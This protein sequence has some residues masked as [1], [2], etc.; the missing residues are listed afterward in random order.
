MKKVVKSCIKHLFDLYSVVMKQIER[1]IKWMDLSFTDIGWIIL[2]NLI[3]SFALV[4]I[5]IPSKITEGG[6]LGLSIVWSK[7]MGT[8]PGLINLPIDIILYVLGFIVLKGGFFKKAIFSTLMY[9]L[10]YAIVENVGPILPSFEQV[11]LVAAVVGGILI[12]I[13]C[14]LVVS[15]GCVAG[16]D[17]CYALIASSKTKLSLSQA[18]FLAD[19]VVLTLSLFVY[20]P[21][22]NVLTSLVTT[23]ISSFIIGQFEVKLPKVTVEVPRIKQA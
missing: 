19:I 11:P 4:N 7:L 17:D 20:M 12:G 10:M 5:H 6:V 8:S 1:F 23:L 14:G 3:M 2:G 18:Y 16:G 22:I 13:G 21:L 9:A 15:R